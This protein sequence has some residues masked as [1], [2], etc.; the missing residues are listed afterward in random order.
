MRLWN[1][2][3]EYRSL[4]VYDTARGTTRRRYT[5]ARRAPTRRGFSLGLRTFLPVASINVS[6]NCLL[7]SPLSSLS[8]LTQSMLRFCGINDRSRKNRCF[9]EKFLFKWIQ[10]KINIFLPFNL[11]KLFNSS[12]YTNFIYDRVDF[13]ER[14]SASIHFQAVT[15]IKAHP[16][17][18]GVPS[19]I[20]CQDLSSEIGC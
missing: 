9:V 20:I 19:T 6:R 1:V 11:R 8:D 15:R 16:S 13:C 4:D 7:L 2:N 10:T 14:N 12:F 17:C 3:I 5:W 18:N